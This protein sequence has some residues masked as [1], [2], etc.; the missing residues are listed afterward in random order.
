MF[1]KINNQGQSLLEVILA[2]AIFALLAATLVTMST[3]GLSS[4]NQSSRQIEANALAQEGVEAVRAI[5]DRAWNELTFTTSTVTTTGGQWVLGTEGTT[6][7]IGD[8][9]RVISL[10]DVCRD[11]GGDLVACPGTYTDVHSKK[12][13]SEVFWSPRAGVTTSV[14]Q[15]SYLTNWDTDVWTQTDWVG[16][17][18]QDTWLDVTKFFS[19]DG[20]VDASTTGQ[21][22]LMYSAAGQCGPMIWDFGNAG[23]YT[24]DTNKIEVIGGF[25]QL[26]DAGSCSGTTSTCATLT[27]SS[28][29]AAQ[30]GCSWTADYALTSPAIYNNHSYHPNQ[31][32]FW[33]GFIETAVKNGGEV[34]YQ[35]SHDDGS[36]WEYWNG[37]AWAA[38]TLAT[39]YNTSTVVNANIASFPTSTKKIMFKAFLSGNG[40]QQ[41]QLD[42]VQINCS[43]QYDWGFD[44]DSDYVYDTSTIIVSTSSAS[45]KTLGGP[46]TCSG[47]ATACN[48]F[49][50]STTCSAQ[51]GCSWANGVSSSTINPG[52]NT[53]TLP[54][55][56]ADWED[57]GNRA[58]GA[59][60]TTGGNPGPYVNITL[61]SSN[62]VNN[63]TLSGYYQQSFTTTANSPTATL[64]FDWR[65]T[66]Y[67]N[68]NLT[69]FILYAFVDSTSG[70][71]VLG[72]Q[73]W[74]Q[75]I[76]AATSWAAVVPIN[77]TTKV[78]TT[79]TYYVKLAARRITAGN[80]SGSNVV[81]FDNIHVDWTNPG[82]CSG[83]ATACNTYV[84]SSTCSVQAGCS[85]SSGSA[86]IYATSSPVIRPVTSL[87]VP[88]TTFYSW[89]GFSETAS[90]GGG[91]IYYQLSNDDGSTWE[92]WNGSAWATAGTS[93]Y[94]PASI[95]NT[96]INT[97]PTS[98]GKLL[99]KA[100]LSSNGSQ[101]VSLDNVSTTWMENVGAS[102][103]AAVGNIMSSA[104]NM[105]NS[106]P[107]SVIS[108]SQNTSTCSGCAIKLKVR[109][110][111]D[112][113]G[114]PGA[115]SSWYGV[116]GAGT[117]FT[118]S[119]GSIIPK[120]LNWNQWVQ[121]QV[122]LSGD[123][124]TTPILNDISIYYK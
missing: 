1:L 78:A 53:A 8:Y 106:S 119:T 43:R 15:V 49:S 11:G 57:N 5:R 94:N 88:T 68:S 87:S 35:L 85:W 64:N 111:P 9:T 100:F 74:S 48:A 86:T 28:T 25:G 63:R 67:S 7:T 70:A 27:S 95:I 3:G 17:V 13:T 118:T 39:H 116:G 58:T 14:K 75:T 40:T 4:L 36:T 72:T 2:L 101:L 84:V 97:F 82:S 46:S 19:N 110:A 124:N 93:S 54:W 123:T 69:S 52:F 107:L 108:W 37:S 102:G 83:T 31:I 99:F 42:Q 62:N 109:T 77:I 24:F 38:A 71:P 22:Q 20:G 21:L 56:Y 60:V 103:Y 89:T 80:S 120:V 55:V 121:Y 73:V 32:A 90:T 45:L 114:A 41:V 76:T 113:A 34:Y 23:P 18:G 12:V 117:Y 61:S 44:L 16:G 105:S 10:S 96:N 50:S 30:S 104:F 29:C 59:R 92:Y 91:A 51:A 6:E 47:T 79:G 98:T 33:S 112:N 115:W 81:G 66:S 122:Q 65:I 26:K